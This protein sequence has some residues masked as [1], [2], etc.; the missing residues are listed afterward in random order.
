MYEVGSK[1]LKN[2]SSCV[3][4]YVLHNHNFQSFCFQKCAAGP[5]CAEEAAEASEAIY[6]YEWGR[7]E[8][9]YEARCEEAKHQSVG[10][11]NRGEA[12][13]TGSV[14][15]RPIPSTCYLAAR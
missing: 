10:G 15:F 6:D 14:R 2:I 4:P 11:K 12:S 9:D 1:Y 13:N 7:V 3:L 8:I 5:H